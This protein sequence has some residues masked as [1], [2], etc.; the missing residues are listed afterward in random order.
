[1]RFLRLGSSDLT[2]VARFG[3]IFCSRRRRRYRGR[4][5]RRCRRRHLRDATR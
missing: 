4:D 2:A 5:G 1:M 3:A